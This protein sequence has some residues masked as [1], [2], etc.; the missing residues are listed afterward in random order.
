MEM[1]KPTIYVT[2]KD[3]EQLIELS[4]ATP[5]ETARL[6]EDELF[7]ANIVAQKD[8]PNDVVTMNSL[9]RFA[10]LETDELREISLVFP[11]NQDAHSNRVSVL[12]PVGAALLGLRVG[13]SI[14]WPML[15]GKTKKLFVKEVL[16]QPE[17]SGDW[18]L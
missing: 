12:S 7:R 17:A 8:I 14:S 6:L 4:E 16:Y 10:D 13:E 3:L 15:K 11:Q 9:V 18:D 5:S 1:T 2:D